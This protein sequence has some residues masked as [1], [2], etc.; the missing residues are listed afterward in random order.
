MHGPI[1]ARQL[2]YCTAC[3]RTTEQTRSSKQDEWVCQ[4]CGATLV[5]YKV[6]KPPRDPEPRC[7]VQAT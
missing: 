7:G 2:R 1:R 3:N 4:T 6:T 5:E